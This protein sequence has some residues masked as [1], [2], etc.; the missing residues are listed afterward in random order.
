MPGNDPARDKRIFL[1]HAISSSIE[2]QGW[3]C[4]GSLYAPQPRTFSVTGSDPSSR[5]F[6]PHWQVKFILLG[7]IA[8]TL[9]EEAI[10]TFMTNL[11]PFF[12]V[13]VGEAYI[14]ACTNYLDVVLLH[15]VIVFVP[16]F[17]A[18]AWILKRLPLVYS[19]SSCFS[20]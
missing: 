14:T 12:G 7:I 16:W 11:A 4:S 20:V 18:W 5:A 3:S 10:T 19:G 13:K 6:R 1:V 17:I 2:A 15:S 8:M 9:L